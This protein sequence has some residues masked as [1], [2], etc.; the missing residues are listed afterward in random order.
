MK[1]KGDAKFKGK[2][3]CGLKNGLRNLLNFHARSWKPVNLYFDGLLLSKAYKDLDEKVQKR[4]VSWH[5]RVLQSLRKTWL[6]VP[7]MIWRF[8]FE[9][10]EDLP[11]N[12]HFD[13]LLLSIAY[14]VTAKK[15]QKSDLSW[16]W[17]EIQTL[18]K[19]WLFIWKMTW[20][21]WWIFTQVVEG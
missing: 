3:T 6:F 1:L 2:L 18:K 19:N 7:K 15:V 11:E 16:H 17:K 5:W 4:Y 14:K 12:L 20:G 21:I 9:K 10:F 13:V 8:A